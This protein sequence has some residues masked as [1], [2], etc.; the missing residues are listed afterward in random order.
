MSEITKK[1][2]SKVSRRSV[3]KGTAAAAGAAVGTGAIS[4]FPTLWAQEKVVL[5]SVGSGVSHIE[6]WQ[7][8]AE[9]DLGIKIEMTA[10]GFDGIQNKILTQPK[11]F[12]IA[13]PAGNQMRRIWG[14]PAAKLQPIEIKRLKHWDE[15]I[16]MYKSSM[17]T[18]SDAKIGD[19][20]HPAK[21]LYN[22]GKK[23]ANKFAKAG[24][25]DYLTFMPTVHNA[26]T[27]GYRRDLVGYEIE[28]WAEMLNPKWK[29]KVCLQAFPDIC[30]MDLAMAIEARGDIKYG[31]KGNM[32]KEEIDKTFVILND[33]KKQGHFRAFWT[34]FMESVNFM[35]NG[36][37][38]IQSMWSPAVTLVQ[39]QGIDVVYADLKEGYRGWTIGNVLAGH[40][41][42]KKLDAAYEFLNWQWAGFPG[43]LFGRQG[44]YA[45]TPE[46]TKKFM[47]ADEYAYWIDGKPTKDGITSPFG[48]PLAKPGDVRDGGSYKNRMGN[49]A[50][51]NSEYDEFAYLVKKWSAFQAA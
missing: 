2:N 29:G 42:G 8:Q 21:V 19:G 32:T 38:V 37:A 13:E 14:S 9:K 45:P 20:Q 18:W 28:T 12:D 22:P 39:T 10:L 41:K 17:K 48:G 1:V 27:L 15:C 30:M 3:L 25:S 33:L 35:T 40:L 23:K 51:W 16:G 49:I 44:Y 26:D 47:S 4:G 5:R 24:G 50:V 7:K 43:A 11:S 31:N 46:R 34:T 6:P 36:E